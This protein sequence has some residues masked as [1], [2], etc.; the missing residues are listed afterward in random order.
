MANT[1]YNND[2]KW[3]NGLYPRL[4][5]NGPNG[6]IV[7][8]GVKRDQVIEELKALPVNEKGF[9][10]DDITISTQKGDPKKMSAYSAPFKK[11]ATYAPVPVGTV[12]EDD[13]GLP[14]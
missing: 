5:Y 11:Q 1:N 10:V 12:A 8:M 13:S 6:V 9:L 4:N 2:R 14:F 3:I 7:G